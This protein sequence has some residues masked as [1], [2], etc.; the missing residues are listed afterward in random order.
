MFSTNKWINLAIFAAVA[1]VV[2][3]VVQ[4]NTHLEA[5]KLVAFKGEAEGNP[6]ITTITFFVGATYNA[7]RVLY[8]IARMA[9]SDPA[10]SMEAQAYLGAR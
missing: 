4:H 8:D 2:V 6:T 7:T 9:L 10:T 5:G 3:L 1:F